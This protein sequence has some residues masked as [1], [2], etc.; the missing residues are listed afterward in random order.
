MGNNNKKTLP[1]INNTNLTLDYGALLTGR[2]STFLKRDE[3]KSVYSTN[4]PLNYVATAR[5][6]FHKKNLYYSFYVSARAPRPRL[7]QFIDDGGRIMEEHTLQQPAGANGGGGISGGP[8]SVYQNATDKICGVWRRVPRDYRKM[9]RDDLISV[10]LLWGGAHQAEL[11]LAG[12]VSKYPALA[13]ELFSALLEPGPDTQPELMGG[14]GGTAIISTSSG[15]TSSIHMTFVL[16]G[17]FGGEEI[18]DVPLSIRLESQEKKQI[19]LEDVVAVAKPANDYNVIEF[20]SPLSPHNLRLLTRGKLIITVASRKHPEMRMQGAIATRVA[21]EHWQA[22][23]VPPPQAP[24]ATAIGGRTRASGLAWIYLNRDGNLVYNVYTDSLNAADVSMITMTDESMKRRTELE[25]LTPAIHGQTAIG[26]IERV[27]PKV[28]E[29]MYADALGINVASEADESLIRGRLVARMVADARDSPEPILLRRVSNA[30][31]ADGAAAHLQAAMAWLSVDSEC[32]LHYEITLGGGVGGGGGITGSSGTQST[33][34][35][36]LEEIPIEAPG[37]PVT[38]HALTTW[39]GHYLEGFNMDMLPADLAKLETSVVYVEVRS[40]S[41]EN[42]SVL[43]L[44]GKLRSMKVPPHCAPYTDNDVPSVY[45]PPMGGEHNDNNQVG[46]GT[47]ESHC[48]DSKRFHKEGDQWK[49]EIE[50]CTMCSCLHG[51]IKC[52]QIK[53]PPLK[54]RPEERRLLR[55]ECCE[56]CVGK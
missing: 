17:L 40:G 1:T 37:A 39:T 50:S 11:A 38:R 36:L 27:G 10:V 7:I 13:T 12:R 35:L 33:F 43:L 26:V 28:L 4:N 54:C 42:G 51:L 21:C 53:C 23:L 20:S 49:S 34:Q 9:L 8:I 14:S 16:N 2:T 6:T 24:G 31:A 25:D 46:V 52:E 32:T 41:D 48:F 55:D 3:I 44:R 5:F 47:A 56:S 18:A 45:Q 15:A 19:V 29:A 30:S 22:L